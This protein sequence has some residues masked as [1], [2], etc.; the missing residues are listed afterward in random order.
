MLVSESVAMLDWL[1]IS[2]ELLD[3]GFAVT[4]RMLSDEDCLGLREGYAKAELYRKTIVMQRYSMGRGEYK[5]F[6]DPLPPLVRELRENL[7]VQL[8]PVADE[9]CRRLGMEKTYPDRHQDF[10]ELCR[11]EGQVEPTPLILRYQAGDYNCLHQDLYG[12]VWFPFQV[13]FG[14]SEPGKDYEGGELVLTKQRPRL[15]TIP[16]VLSI[17]KGAAV[18]TTTNFHPEKSVKG[19][20]RA[21]MRHGV[22]EIR[23][24]ERFTLG[25]IFHNAR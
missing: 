3:R 13:I 20:Y 10:L 8:S 11:K 25:I 6:A 1:R 14:L 7:Y 19:H 16:Y 5:Y 18:I 23:S 9:W 17:P 21:L 24:G 2:R 22:G 12:E 4:G 15:Q